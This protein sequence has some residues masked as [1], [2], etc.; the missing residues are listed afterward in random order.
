MHLNSASICLKPNLQSI[1][2]HFL[3]WLKKYLLPQI[4]FCLIACEL[5]QAQFRCHSSTSKADF[6]GTFQLTGTLH[7]IQCTHCSHLYC[8][9]FSLL[10]KNGFF[11]KHNINDCT[12]KSLM[13]R[14]AEE[15]ALLEVGDLKTYNIQGNNTKV[16]WD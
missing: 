13:I 4:S 8:V 7:N 12:K 14:T 16:F 6:F 1:L 15:I 5:F 10:L 9:S 11:Q 3:F 2:Q